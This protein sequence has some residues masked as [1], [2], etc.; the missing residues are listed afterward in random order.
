MRRWWGIELSFT[1]PRGR[2]LDHGKGII[3]PPQ[4]RICTACL[5]DKE[6]LRRCNQSIEK[7]VTRLRSG[8]ELLGPCHMG[9][10]I[11]GTPISFAGDRQGS[12]FA[13]GFLVS[14]KA[15]RA[16]D[17]ALET[18][19]ALSLPVAEPEAAFE[20]IQRI[21]AREVPRLADSWTRPCRRSTPTT[22]PSCCGRS[23]SATSSKR[24]WGA[25]A[26]TT[27]SASAR[28]MRRLYRLLD[29]VID[30]DATVLVHGENGTGKELI[31]RAIHYNSPRAST[32]RSWCRTARAFND[33]LLDSELFGHKKGAFTGAI[34]DKQGLFEVAD[35]GTFFL[36][37]IG[38][39]SPA[40]Q[41]KLLRVL[42]E[43]TFTPVGGT[44]PRKVDVRII[45]A[46]NSDLREDGASGRVPRGPLLPHQRDPAARCRRCASGA[47]T[48]PSWSST[49]STQR[50]NA[51]AAQ[52]QAAAPG[53]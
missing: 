44:R 4:N 6:G 46:T 23:A 15:P 13:C 36:D 21:E 19:Q 50:R 51:A 25:T 33:N 20:N 30:S 17:R 49:S 35:G 3:I 24:W 28:P 53:V 48:C 1:D 37:E 5:G 18:V 2:P 8:T 29:K 26:S 10:E 27:S 16:R 43:G 7:A 34:A 38:D 32:S 31:A 9:L 41:V 52:A 39:M 14:E 22:R 45:A 42:Q 11:V 40:L 47:T 12:L